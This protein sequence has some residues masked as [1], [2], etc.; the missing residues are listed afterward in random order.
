MK[1]ETAIGIG[2]AIVGLIVGVA[3]YFVSDSHN[4]AMV[5]IGGGLFFIGLA[6]IR[7]G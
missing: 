3:G 1:T 7:R 2:L 6:V 5:V 4:W